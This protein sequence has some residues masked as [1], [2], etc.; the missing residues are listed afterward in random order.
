MFPVPTASTRARKRAAKT[1]TN[2]RGR[3]LILTVGREDDCGGWVDVWGGDYA[4]RVTGRE[5]KPK[6]GRERSWGASPWSRAGMTALALFHC[7][8]EVSL[9]IPDAERAVFWVLRALSWAAAFGRCLLQSESSCLYRAFAPTK[10][11]LSNF[12]VFATTR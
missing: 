2:D 9:R 1:T 3:T 8:F 4:A 10:D 6:N 7:G 5:G 12:L 11:H